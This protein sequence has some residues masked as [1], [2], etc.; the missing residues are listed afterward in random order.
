MSVE[1]PEGTITTYTVSVKDG[2]NVI[3]STTVEVGQ[4]SST[5]PDQP[6]APSPEPVDPGEGQDPQ[7]P[8]DPGTPIPEQPG[9]QDGSVAGDVTVGAVANGRADVTVSGPIGAQWMITGEGDSYVTG[10]FIEGRS[11]TRSI[12]VGTGSVKTFTLHMAGGTTTF[13]VD[14]G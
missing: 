2:L 9:D 10:G 1:A 12:V 7:V 8:V 14:A 6:V 13:T 4:S 3:G 5:E 11:I